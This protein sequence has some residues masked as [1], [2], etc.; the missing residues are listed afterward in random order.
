M[1]GPHQ[2]IIWRFTAGAQGAAP[3]VIQRSEERSYFFFTSAGR[4]SRRTNM[5][6]TMC[7]WLT[8]CLSI[9]RSMSSASKRG[10][11]TIESPSRALL[12]P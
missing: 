9:S 5:V 10:C 4:R 2:S 6:G 3:W 1:T 8:R 11:S 7:M 12:M